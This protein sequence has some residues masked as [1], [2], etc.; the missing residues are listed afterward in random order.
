MFTGGAV[1]LEDIQSFLVTGKAGD[2]IFRGGDPG[3]EMYIV[4]QG[5]IELAWPRPGG[6]IDTVV[7]RAGEFFGEESLFEHQPRP[8]SARALTDYQLIR[9]DAAALTAIVNE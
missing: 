9:V 4:R 2:E 8:G 1:N 7:V 5:Q 6:R 3:A